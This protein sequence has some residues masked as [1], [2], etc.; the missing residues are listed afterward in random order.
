MSE[1]EY[2]GPPAGD[3]EPAA[4]A[5]EPDGA[6]GPDGPPD[7]PGYDAPAYAPGYDAGYDDA[8][9]DDAGYDTPGYDT[10]PSDDPGALRSALVMIATAVVV[11]A[12]GAPL[13]WLWSVL[14]PRVGYIKT[15]GG[16]LYADSEPEQAMAA[17]G[18][19]LIIGAAAGLVL[20]VLVWVALRR[21]RGVAMLAA[22]TVGS[23][24][25]AMLAW[26]LG[27]RIGMSQFNQ[28]NAAAVNGDRIDGPLGLRITNLTARQGW[29]PLLTG[30]AAGQALVAALVY[31]CLA[32]FS[33]YDNLRGPGRRAAPP[34]G[35]G[36]SAASG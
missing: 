6:A 13:G 36:Q 27:H 24:G 16:F 9:Y 12:L 14:A 7:A 3:S 4:P 1:R 22:L 5:A 34:A 10:E 29:K 30:V 25:G 18:W 17:D 28:A 32:G 15:D 35:P 19:F 23:L 31:T 21:Y 20:A 2:G 8:G 26:W 33:V 11:A